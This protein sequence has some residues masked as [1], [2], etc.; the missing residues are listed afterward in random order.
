MSYSCT[1][2][3]AVSS[4]VESGLEAQRATCAPPALRVSISTA[5]SVV[6]CRHAPRRMPL[7][8]CS[9]VKRSRT[10]R[11]T[12]IDCSAHSIRR[13]PSAASERFLT[14]WST[15]EPRPFLSFRRA[16]R[17][18][19]ACRGDDRTGAALIGSAELD[20]RVVAKVLDA[21]RPFPRE[22]GLRAPEV[23]V[24]RGLFVDRA[25]ELEVLDDAGRREVEVPPHQALEDLVRD[26][27]RAECVDHD[28]DWLGDADRVGDLNLRPL[29]QSG[30]HDVLG[31]VARHVAGGAV[32]FRRILAREGTA[33]V[34]ARA[35][36]RVDDDLPSGETGVAHRP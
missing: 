34:R 11:S 4:W 26:L 22:L 31:N 28:R 24:R 36:V 2:A 19:L 30:R 15:M 10:W 33:A 17:A 5:V 25:A 27:A 35:S 21:V 16:P 1:S 13:R 6:T 29:G 3:A 9:C 7:S 12:A 23:A 32:D 8:G 18:G 20:P 14:S